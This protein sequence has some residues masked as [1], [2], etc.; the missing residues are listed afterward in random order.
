MADKLKDLPDFYKNVNTPELKNA[1]IKI[2]QDNPTTAI[3]AYHKALCKENEKNGWCGLM[4]LFRILGALE[5]AKNEKQN[6]MLTRQLSSSSVQSDGPEETKTDL[7]EEHDR[8]LNNINEALIELKNKIGNMSS[9]NKQSSS[10]ASIKESQTRQPEMADRNK[11][12]EAL[13]EEIEQLNNEHKQTI[14]EIENKHNKKLNEEEAPKKEKQEKI[15]K[16]SKDI[17]QIKGEHEEKLKKLQE[18]SLQLKKS[19]QRNNT[20]QEEIEELKK[21]IAQLNTSNKQKIEEL[22]KDH[23]IKLEEEKSKIEDTLELWKNEGEGI[24]YSEGGNSAELPISNN[25][26]KAT[27]AE[28]KAVNRNIGNNTNANNANKSVVNTE[29]I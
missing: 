10:E 3:D 4:N 28:L 5:E 17:E 15:D 7:N 13:N 20:T 16:L 21:N 11:E 14:Q 8:D 2:L 23:K 27:D 22:Q 9:K 26:K 18:T 12:I 24:V 6:T 29:N 19:N 25:I 1:W